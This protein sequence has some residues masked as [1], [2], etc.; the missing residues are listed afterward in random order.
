MDHILNQLDLGIRLA[1]ITAVRDQ[2]Q[3]EMLSNN[4]P[5][6]TLLEGERRMRALVEVLIE[7][8]ARQADE[9]LPDQLRHRA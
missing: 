7:L 9:L 5:G 4:R 2:L 6:V 3:A 8:R 1:T